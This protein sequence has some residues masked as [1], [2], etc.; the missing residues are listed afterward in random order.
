MAASPNWPGLAPGEHGILNALSPKYTDWTG[1][2]DLSP[3]PPVLWTHGT[4]DQVINDNSPL[5]LATL[6]QLGVVPGWPGADVV[7]PQPMLGQLRDF[8][9]A[10]GEKGGR[11]ETEMFEGSGHFP[12]ADAFDR[13]RKVFTDF[14]A[15]VREPAGV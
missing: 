2:A 7:P 12:V 13:W 8:F 9:T 15:S 4:A 11:V 5:D 14:L 6:G 3:K 10:Y 1:L